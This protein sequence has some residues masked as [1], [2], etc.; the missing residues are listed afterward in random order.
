MVVRKRVLGEG[1]C[2]VGCGGGGACVVLG[3]ARSRAEMTVCSALLWGND[4]L[5][6]LLQAGQWRCYRLPD[7][8]LGALIKAEYGALAAAKNVLEPKRVA[9]GGISSS[10][11]G[12]R[13]LCATRLPS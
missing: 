7:G 2:A 4:R 13:V 11:M 12:T 9:S 1:G 5:D 3:G 8:L 6:A 10:T